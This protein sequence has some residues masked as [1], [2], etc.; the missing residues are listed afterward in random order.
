MRGST[1]LSPRH[2][3]ETAGT[4][5]RAAKTQVTGSSGTGP[6]AN[7]S[8]NQGAARKKVLFVC[9]GN[10]CRSQMAEAFARAYGGDILIASSAGLSPASMIPPLTR[11]VLAD[12]NIS[13]ADQF[14]KGMEIAAHERFDVVVNLSGLP[15][16]LSAAR[17]LTW[18]V[19]D[20]VGYGEP[21]FR[22]VAAQIEELV[23]RL[24]LELRSAGQ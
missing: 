13:T 8:S 12:R 17:S 16:T 22:N 19:K 20:P 3:L 7:P 6:S 1:K 14:P 4:A 24:I 23:M 21:I 2:A 10:A 18:Q 11:K 9:I 15:L 5:E